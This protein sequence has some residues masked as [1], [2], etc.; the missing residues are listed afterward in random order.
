[1]IMQKMRSTW[2]DEQMRNLLGTLLRI[3]VL[4]SAAVVIFGGILFFI[5]HPDETIDFSIF[6]S[7]PARLRN[8]HIIIMEALHLKSRSVIQFGL[9]IL[10]ATPVVRVLFS[11]VGFVIEKDKIY[12]VITAVVLVILC[13]SLFSSYITF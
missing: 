13:S 12:I 7:E 9:L 10:I 2:G 4:T 5:Q 3:G 8:V 11:L 6:K 1:M